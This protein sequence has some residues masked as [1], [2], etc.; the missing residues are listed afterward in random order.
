MDDHTTP[1]LANQ[2]SVRTAFRVLGPV[3]LVVGLGFVVTVAR[4][5]ADARFCDSRGQSLA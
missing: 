2:S 4:Y 3:L 5:V 1:G